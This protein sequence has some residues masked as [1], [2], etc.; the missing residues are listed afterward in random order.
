MATPRITLNLNRKNIVSKFDRSSPKKVRKD[1][2]RE[3]ALKL[4]SEEKRVRNLVELNFSRLCD[5]NKVQID[6]KSNLNRKELIHVYTM[7]VAMFLQ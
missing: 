4:V 6:T 1:F 3:N 7:F 2:L 5:L